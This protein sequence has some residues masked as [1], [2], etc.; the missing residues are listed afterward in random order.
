M[1][2]IENCS[3]EI[4]GDMGFE[5]YY[6]ACN[7]FV[8]ENEEFVL[9][10]FSRSSTSSCHRWAKFPLDISK[11]TGFIFSDMTEQ[12]SIHQVRQHT[13]IKMSLV[14]AIIAVSLSPLVDLEML[15]QKF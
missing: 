1:S 3:M 13:H 11:L 10:C 2:K 7:T 15:I 4:I 6:G 12:I 14:W 5:F 8:S 9:L